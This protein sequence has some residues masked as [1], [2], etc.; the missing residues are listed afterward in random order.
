MKNVIAYLPLIL[1]WSFMKTVTSLKHYWG[2]HRQH[3]HPTRIYLHYEISLNL[4]MFSNIP[5]YHSTHVY[6]HIWE[7]ET[8]PLLCSSEYQFSHFGNGHHHLQNLKATGLHSFQSFPTK[9]NKFKVQIEVILRGWH[10]KG[11]ITEY[12]LPTW[13]VRVTGIEPPSLV[14][15]GSTPYTCLV[16]L[17]PAT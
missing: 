15:S 2:K 7:A 6:F 3:A 13:K 8:L 17:R 14:K 16:A 1:L 4:N 9:E 12:Y 5:T 10:N 11:F